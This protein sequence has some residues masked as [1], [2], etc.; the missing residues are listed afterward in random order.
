[1]THP[2]LKLI[3]ALL[4]NM[5]TMEMQALIKGKWEDISMDYLLNDING[6]CAYRVKP[7]CLFALN[8]MEEYADP[9]TY[10]AY[11][12]YIEGN[13]IQRRIKESK[14]VSDYSYIEHGFHDFPVEKDSTAWMN[15]FLFFTQ[16]IHG[17][18]SFK[19]IDHQYP[20]FKL[21]KNEGGDFRVVKFTGLKSG[22]VVL[23]TYKGDE[24]IFKTRLIE[25]TNKDI[26]MDLPYDKS[27]GFYHCQPVWFDDSVPGRTYCFY[28]AN[29]NSAF[30]YPDNSGFEM[31]PVEDV[32]EWMRELFY[33]ISTNKKG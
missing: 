27:T 21:I 30:G 11:V 31:Q 22:T 9:D 28:D 24:G 15:P 1:M 13:T 14:N 4:S 29:T 20:I 10:D 12:S 2:N 6:S 5:D 8:W 16:S 33:K 3:V 32:P 7:D 19:C 18:A 26:W 17:G 25:H 23:S